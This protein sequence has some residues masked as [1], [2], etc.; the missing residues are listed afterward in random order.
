MISVPFEKI[1]LKYID[2]YSEPFSSKQV[3]SVTAEALDCYEC[4]YLTYDP[5]PEGVSNEGDSWC[6][7]GDRIKDEVRL[8]ARG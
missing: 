1:L 6:T 4:S 2:F 3:Y 5:L 7:D 8:L